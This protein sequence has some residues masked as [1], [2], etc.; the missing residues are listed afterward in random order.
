MDITMIGHISKDIMHYI[1]GVQRFTGGP[2]IYSSAAAARAGKKIRV[3][4]RAAREDDG[5]LKGMRA[6]GVEVIRLDSPE[7][8]RIFFKGWKRTAGLIS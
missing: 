1:D 6:L 8:W 5:A 2:V 3:V 7:T 4:T